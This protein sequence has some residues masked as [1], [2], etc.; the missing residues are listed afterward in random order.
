MA[1][2]NLWDFFVKCPEFDGKKAQCFLCNKTLCCTTVANLKTHLRLKHT[3]VVE[4]MPV[5][6]TSIKSEDDPLTEKIAVK[7]ADIVWKNFTR[8][9]DDSKIASC[10]HC[11]RFYSYKTTIT[12]LKVHLKTVHRD[13]YD[14]LF[15]NSVQC[16]GE[17]EEWDVDN[18]EEDVGNQGESKDINYFNR[19][20]QPTYFN[21][22]MVA[23][24]AVG[25]YPSS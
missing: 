18:A 10:N 13:I 25:L 17:E 6:V 21:R 5:I 20:Y 14:D 2:T 4:T 1:D 19:Y 23:V 11:G 12:N 15:E 16:L 3:D 8:A 9:D 7:T 22:A 24:L